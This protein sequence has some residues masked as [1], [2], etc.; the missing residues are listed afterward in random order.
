MTQTVFFLVLFGALMHA[1][2]NMVIKLSP[3]KILETG[4]MNLTRSAI[5]FPA[6]IY[7]GIPEL[8]TWPYLATSLLLHIVYYYTLVGAYKW[9]DMSL[10]YPI[11]RGAAPIFLMA[12]T[13]LLTEDAITMMSFL[14]VIIACSGIICLA[15][16][17][18]IYRTH[19]KKSIQF[20]LL[21]AVVIALYTVVDGIGVRKSSVVFS[22]IAMFMF[23]DGCLFFVI[24]YF[25]RGASTRPIKEYI[26]LR[27]PYFIGGAVATV[28]SYGI[29]LWAMTK[30]PISIVSALREVSV[31]FAFLMAWLF[32][33]EKITRLRIVGIVLIIGGGIAINMSG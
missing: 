1:L 15:L 29:A 8:N 16:G 23:L 22:Y 11:M 25:K 5:V 13:L 30:V 12:L 6:V 10:A 32:L 19:A 20:A 14:G 2:W 31:L 17:N 18:T 24:L 27:W 4:L 28:L 21:N 9:G 26:N 3:D 7:F 33:K